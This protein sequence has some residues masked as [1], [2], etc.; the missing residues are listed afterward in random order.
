VE[1]NEHLNG[2]VTGA[3]ALIVATSDEEIAGENFSQKFAG[4][5]SKGKSNWCRIVS[6]KNL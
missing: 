2:T 1:F 3:G 6:E 5:P 4:N